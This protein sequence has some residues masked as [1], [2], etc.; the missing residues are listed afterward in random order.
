MIFLLVDG[1]LYACLCVVCLVGSHRVVL[2]VI[3]SLFF[4]VYFVL[5]F[6]V[7]FVIMS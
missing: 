7:N 6:V 1:C 4:L 3:A 2:Y 5:M